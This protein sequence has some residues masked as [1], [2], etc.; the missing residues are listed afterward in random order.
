M[1]KLLTSLFLIA[2]LALPSVASAQFQLFPGE[3]AGRDDYRVYIQNFYRFSIAAGILIATVLIMIGGIMWTTSAG[4]HGRIDK[5][6][7]YIKD[8][9]IGVILLIGAYTILSLIN[10]NLVNLPKIVFP[11]ISLSIGACMIPKNTAGGKTCIDSTEEG[12]PA[13]QTDAT[14]GTPEFSK[15]IPC[16]TACPQ[17]D[18]TTGFCIEQ[19]A[20]KLKKL[21]DEQKAGS[22]KSTDEIRCEAQGNYGGGTPI[23]DSGFNIFETDDGLCNDYC[24]GAGPNCIV[25][26]TNDI[27]GPTMICKCRYFVPPPTPTFTQPPR[28]G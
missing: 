2:L 3:A 19:D 9:I 10:P 7:E 4:D 23:A 21:T 18:P 5:A 13:L 6:K 16:S 17:K 22:G 27:D 15:D 11:K 24:R 20:T 25:A 8:S 12:C 26:S 1:K 28:A 14:L